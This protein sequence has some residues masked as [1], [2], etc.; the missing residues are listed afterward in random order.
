[1]MNFRALIPG[2]TALGMVVALGGC[3]GEKIDQAT[4]AADLRRLDG[5]MKLFGKLPEADLSNDAF[6]RESRRVGRETGP[7]IIHAIMIRGRSFRGEE[8]L[9]FV[10]LVTLLD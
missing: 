4:L 3:A 7:R 8:G 6:W 9:V 2:V 10:P 5:L 1:G